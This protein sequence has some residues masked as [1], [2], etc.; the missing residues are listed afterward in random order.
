[1]ELK[2][3]GKGGTKEND[4]LKKLDRIEEA[5]NA[6]GHPMQD[7]STLK[8]ALLDLL[9]VVREIAGKGK[10]DAPL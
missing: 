1:M 4:V 9:E 6:K 7:Y 5:I 2:R 3:R 8:M 10:K